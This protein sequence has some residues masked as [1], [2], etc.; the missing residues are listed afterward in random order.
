MQPLSQA[1]PAP[2]RDTQLFQLTLFMARASTAHHTPHKNVQ[3]AYRLK[4]CAPA[5][6]PS[7]A[8]PCRSCASM[9]RSACQ[10][11]GLF[12]PPGVPMRSILRALPADPRTDTPGPSPP[13]PSPRLPRR[14]APRPYA[15][16]AKTVRLPSRS[17]CTTPQLAPSDVGTALQMR[18]NC[19]EA[20]NVFA[21]HC[22]VKCSC[23]SSL[24]MSR[25]MH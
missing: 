22:N 11:S 15:A 17:S 13:Q 7:A 19:M 16:P 21:V 1:L 23:G 10:A 12:A 4:W 14:Q 18:T 25:K 5:V 6:F 3:G 2:A 24:C 20:S 8:S 9:L